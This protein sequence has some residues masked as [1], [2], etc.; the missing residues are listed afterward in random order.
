MRISK[1][2]EPTFNNVNLTANAQSPDGIEFTRC[3]SPRVN[4]T[5]VIGGRYSWFF[6]DGTRGGRVSQLTALDAFHAVA[7]A[8]FTADL[9]VD[10][11]T[12]NNCTSLLDVH[13]AFDV[14]HKNVVDVAAS[15]GGLNNRGDG[16]GLINAVL[17]NG[18]GF[19]HGIV[20]LDNGA[21]NSPR[22]TASNQ[23]PFLMENVVAPNYIF[24][25]ASEV[26][27]VNNECVFGELNQNLAGA[28]INPSSVHISGSTITTLGLRSPGDT[29]DLNNSTFETVDFHSSNAQYAVVTI[30]GVT[31]SGPGPLLPNFAS[32]NVERRRMT[33]TNSSFIYVPRDGDAEANDG[34]LATDWPN[35]SK[36]DVTFDGCIFDGVTF[37]D[38]ASSQSESIVYGGTTP[39]TYL[40]GAVDQDE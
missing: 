37:A 24:A 21:T 3:V 9:E 16:G 35:P 8:T 2:V 1:A 12:G 38:A 17:S 30:D 13:P 23:R 14:V 19:T 39:N 33:V 15:G 11:A 26:A 4:T 25:F 22:L 27:L 20:W 34:K 29:V 32:N 10:G 18:V 36:L 5:S 28:Q 6:I 7:T 40:N 31:V